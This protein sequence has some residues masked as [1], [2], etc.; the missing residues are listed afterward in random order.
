MEILVT[1]GNLTEV[2]S[3]LV[4]INEFEGVKKPGGATGA[5]N[6]AI[7]N[8]IVTLMKEE[9]FKGKKGETLLIRTSDE[10]ASKRVLLMG[11]GK[12]EDFNTE[13]IREVSAVSFQM[14]KKI[15]ARHVTSILHGAGAG[16]IES[17][18]AL[19]AMVEGVRFAEYNFDSYK[20]SQTK[21]VVE[22]FEIVSTNP[23][24]VRSA[25]RVLEKA[26][27]YARGTLY[28]RELVDLPPSETSP[29]ELV[30]RAKEISKASGGLISVKV[31]DMAECKK[32]GMNAFLGIAQG[33]E[34]KP[35]FVHM[36]Y[37]PKKAVKKHL[38]L[39]GKAITFDSGGLSIKPAQAMYTMKLD[40]AGA[41]SVIGVFSILAELKPNMKIDGIFAA[42]E[43]MPS[44][45]AI[46]PGD[47]VKALNGKTIEV[48]HTDAEG[49][50]T[51]ADA[52]SYA[53]KQ[54]PDYIVDL[55][56]LTGAC[57]VALGEEYVGVM[58]NN[59]KLEEKI[60]QAAARA[61]ENFWA[62]PLEE[63]YRQAI[64]SEVADIKNIGGKWAGTITAGLFL[65]EFIEKTP[66]VHLDIA[67]P[68]FAERK[69]NA[70]TSKGATG[71][72][73]RTLLELINS[74]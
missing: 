6:A 43:N 32:R 62:L 63:N 10:I 74:L 20:K 44:G 54:K 18:E 33:S 2:E 56:T 68:A 16:K 30:K 67:G 53:E 46:K 61:D 27:L 41:A 48:L 21:P 60:L 13:V 31:M 35:F 24:H 38:S 73:V 34:E 40:M 3:D 9:G 36:T 11:L 4:V 64:K 52:L 72:P 37:K 5:V 71:A 22:Q 49:R 14:A 25:K 26:E 23:N 47:V 51:L 70:Y 17:K 65:S 45:T 15:G 50:V 7:G 66:W 57:V 55:A 8:R 69:F 58:S 59:S 39:V 28:A 12:K 19:K 42:C 1:K 29:A